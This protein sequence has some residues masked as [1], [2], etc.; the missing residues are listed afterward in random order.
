MVVV[1]LMSSTQNKSNSHAACTNN[2]VMYITPLVVVAMV[3]S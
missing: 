2:L 3:L 1:V